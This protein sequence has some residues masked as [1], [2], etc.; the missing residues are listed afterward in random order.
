ME[1]SLNSTCITR[2]LR[3]LNSRDRLL[4][5]VA[6]AQ[7]TA[8]VKKRTGKEELRDTDIQNFLNTAPSPGEAR[9]GD[10]KST[11]S[12]VRK[13]LKLL[14]C[15]VEVSGTKVTLI[16]DDA[17]AKAGKRAALARI[18]AKAKTEQRLQQLTPAPDQGRS[19]HLLFKHPSSNHW[20]Q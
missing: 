10:V 20:I 4:Q 16:Y 9:K 6:W 18:L 1:D 19:F 11:W 12:T 17:S 7:L 8:V 13:S 5:D 15:K 14:G 2:I 3:C